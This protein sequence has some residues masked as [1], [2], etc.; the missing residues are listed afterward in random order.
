MG[1]MIGLSIALSWIPLFGGLI[2]GFVG[3][4]KAGN[5]PTALTAVFLPGILLFLV[6]SVMGARVG[7]IRIIGRL[8]G[9]MAGAGGWMLSFMNVIPLVIGAAIGGATVDKYR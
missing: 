8:G 3:G 2:A 9:A 7:W 1:W 5:V 6:T 4:R